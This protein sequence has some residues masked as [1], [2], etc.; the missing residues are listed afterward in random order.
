[1]LKIILIMSATSLRDLSLKIF[2][3][4]PLTIPAR[5]RNHCQKKT[6][7]LLSKVSFGSPCS[8]TGL[9]TL[10]GTCRVV[11]TKHFFVLFQMAALPNT[12]EVI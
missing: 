3:F 9:V 2:K 5:S 1:M 7:Q 12:L 8:K 11:A 4:L 10:V 6:Y